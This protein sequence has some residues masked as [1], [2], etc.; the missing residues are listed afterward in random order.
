MIIVKKLDKAFETESN[1]FEKTPSPT[2]PTNTAKNLKLN[3]KVIVT[4]KGKITLNN[5][6]IIEQ[7][8]TAFFIKTEHE[9]KKS[10]PS[11]T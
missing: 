6:I 7:T 2:K 8:P 11:E 9:N 4:T 3:I 1:K 5:K 10:N